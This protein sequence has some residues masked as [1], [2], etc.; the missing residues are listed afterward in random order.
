VR[1]QKP[2]NA[3]QIVMIALLVVI[4]LSLK[5]PV[6]VQLALAAALTVLASAYNSNRG[7]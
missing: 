2:P 3:D 7:G 5:A 1:T 6:L 4:A